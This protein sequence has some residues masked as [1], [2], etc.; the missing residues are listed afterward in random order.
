MNNNESISAFARLLATENIV[1]RHSSDAQT[2]SFG[3]VDRVLTLPIWRNMTPA[4]YDMLV[5]HEVAHALWTDNTVDKDLGCLAACVE[6]APDNPTSAMPVINV[7]EDARIERL[8]KSKYPGLKRDFVAGYK[9]LFDMD[10]FQIEE[11]GGVSEMGFLDRLNLY[12]KI[13]IL[14]HVNVPF[15]ND[16]EI[17]FRDRIADATTWEDVVEISRDLYEYDMQQQE[18]DEQADAGNASAPMS[19]DSKDS[20]ASGMPSSATQQQQQEQ[21]EDSD[22]DSDSSSAGDGDESDESSSASGDDSEDTSEDAS[23]SQGAS[24][25]YT[26]DVSTQRAMDSGLVE[27]NPYRNQRDQ[28][29][30]T[31][32][33]PDISKMVVSA[34]DIAERHIGC[35]STHY[36]ELSAYEITKR[37]E[38]LATHFSM[39][40]EFMTG[41]NATVNYLAKQFEMRKAADIH[42]RTMSSKTGRLDPI[43]M[44]NYRWSEDIFA[45]NQ[46][47]RDG[48]N[49]GFVAV[50]DWSGSM[51]NNLLSTV[52]QSIT[53]AMFCRKVNIPFDLY[54]F[55]DRG[56]F[57]NYRAY[58][59]RN[60]ITKPVRTWNDTN[61]TEHTDSDWTEKVLHDLHMLNFL[62]SSMNNRQFKTACRI[63]YSLACIEG[64]DSS[65]RHLP[66]TVTDIN[67]GLGGTPLDESLVAMHTLLP[68]FRAKH[69]VQVLN[70]VL[71]SDGDGSQTFGEDIILNPITR[72]SYG[73]RPEERE[74]NSTCLLLQS[75]KETTGCNLI[76]MYLHEGRNCFSVSTGWYNVWDTPEEDQKEA[77]KSW[78]N[79]NY[80]IA[81][82]RYSKFFDEAYII[83]ANVN[84]DTDLNLPD[85]GTRTNLRNAF[86]KGMKSRGMSRNLS[87]RFIE[88]VAR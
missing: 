13:G 38:N 23:S 72:R 73:A 26:P 54:A 51:C 31:M 24:S 53:L 80:Y 29:I 50:L 43:K 45:K 81:N 58:G 32:P 22:S 79:N 18:Q 56:D 48:K 77:K 57:T 28:K 75:L 86:V 83:N 41:E 55:S 65:T 59:S 10:L 74:H 30:T 2:A 44:I 21:S 11:Q 63:L 9:H 37:S 36:G 61:Y 64:Y 4:L 39:C 88:V 6:V 84:P 27:Q 7:V 76:G 17:W 33:T 16:T 19:N 82:G 25:G 69:G 14:G 47:V 67:L 34:T 12:F 46:T 5:G 68:Q 20:D 40:D 78:K 35:K 49:H 60:P 8:I 71:L 3:M 15:V 52:R 85:S 87:N 1:V 70:C 66:H 62:S 42:K